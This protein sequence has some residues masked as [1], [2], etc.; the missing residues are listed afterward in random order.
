MFT[1][2]WLAAAPNSR[3]GAT[4]MRDALCFVA[5]L[6]IA[7]PVNAQLSYSRSI[8]GTYDRDVEVTY[9]KLGGWEGRLD[10]YSRNDAP[11]PR[12]TVVYFHG[13]GALGADKGRTASTIDIVPYLEWGW[14][15]VN[16]EWGVPGLT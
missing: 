8:T 10:I 5:A 3:F 9:L 13:G 7:A 6:S 1:L 11:A 15:V 16:V 2:P 14:D 12:P 4:T